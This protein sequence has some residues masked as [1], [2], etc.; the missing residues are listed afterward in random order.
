MPVRSS[1]PARACLQQEGLGAKYVARDE[2]TS[3]R[4]RAGRARS[5]SLSLKRPPT[6]RGILSPLLG[7]GQSL[8]EVSRIWEALD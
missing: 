8:N 4:E 2:I 7:K 5:T 6:S 3:T 1:L